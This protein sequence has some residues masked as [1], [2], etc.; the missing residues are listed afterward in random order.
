[1]Q[2]V[3]LS[4]HLEPIDENNSLPAED[5]SW[6][7]IS[8]NDL[9]AA[10]SSAI[11]YSAPYFTLPDGKEAGLSHLFYVKVK[12]IKDLRTPPTVRRRKQ[13]DDT[14]QKRIYA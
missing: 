14:R 5:Y 8:T 1:M 2:K 4:S 9:N 7:T 6:A 10:K 11:I 3:V 13:S 12:S